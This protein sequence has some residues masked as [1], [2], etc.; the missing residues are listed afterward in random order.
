ME[1]EK[2]KIRIR[3]IV[4]SV[5]PLLSFIAVS[6]GATYAMYL[7]SVVGN[8]DNGEIALKSADIQ[9]VFS[10]T[11]ALKMD[12]MLPGYSGQIEF[13][14]MNSSEED[15]VI[16]DYY[17]MWDI[18]TNEIDDNS[19]VYTLTA[20][21]TKDGEEILEDDTNKVI[22]IPNERRIPGV[23]TNIGKGT[24]NTGVVHRYKLTV[25]FN[26]TLENQDEL[27]GKHFEGKIAAKGD[28]SV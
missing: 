22:S 6:I 24:I 25:K 10:A 20:T 23:S 1:K 4:I 12:E 8:E 21:S 26:E 13:T 9:V 15:D 14:I 27:Q 11:D 2:N 17:L 3:D 28:P 18:I 16:G 19:F 5:I 7:A